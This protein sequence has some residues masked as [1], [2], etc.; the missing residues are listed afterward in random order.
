L[1]LIRL[2]Q[3]S[4]QG[5]FLICFPP[6]CDS[7]ISPQQPIYIKQTSVCIS[8][9]H[10]SVSLSSIC[11]STVVK[12]THPNGRSVRSRLVAG[13]KSPRSVYTY[14]PCHT[15]APLDVMHTH[16]HGKQTCTSHG[17]RNTSLGRLLLNAHAKKMR[18]AFARVIACT[19]TFHDSARRCARA[20]HYDYYHDELVGYES[21]LFSPS[22]SVR[23]CAWVY[24]W[25]FTSL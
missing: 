22:L 9:C 25:L 3:T 19:H 4:I 2:P 6:L 13:I 14:Y 17:R 21:L 7:F 8:S 24:V 12:P 5:R 10:L 1:L 18:G 15:S 11:P 20:L 23:L 16:I